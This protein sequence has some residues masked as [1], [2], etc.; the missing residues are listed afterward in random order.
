ML[1][2]IVTNLRT[3]HWS[4]AF[5]ELLI[6]AVGILMAFQVD[7][8]WEARHERE[9]EQQY[10]GS[11]VN[12]L[13]SDLE[14][15]EV[16]VAQAEFRL[17][18]A[19]LLMDI[20]ENPELATQSPVAF[21]IAVHQAAYTYTPALASNTFD[22]LRSTG[23]IGLLRDMELKNSLFDYYRF[24]ESERQYQ[25]LQLM[26]EFRHFELGAGVLTNQ[27]LRRAHVDWGIVR[28]DELEEFRNDTVD[29]IAIKAAAERLQANH[30]FVAWLPIA[31]EMQLELARINGARQQ[32]ANVLLEI[33]NRLRN[34]DWSA[35]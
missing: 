31:H 16:A 1:G 33:L 25:S 21:T 22:E 6:V 17:F 10:I 8:W 13:E 24:D 4:Q 27:Q 35:S 26:Q 5:F 32:R 2:R 29:L 20:A 23:Y 11:L 7:R 34:E 18:L 14:N 12:D 19:R 3:Q 28:A 15:L 30:S 9:L